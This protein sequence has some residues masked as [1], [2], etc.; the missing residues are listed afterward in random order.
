MSLNVLL[1]YPP[2]SEP[3]WKPIKAAIRNEGGN[4]HKA[5]DQ[6][7]LLAKGRTGKWDLVVSTL[8]LA[9]SP[10][11]QVVDSRGGL[12]ALATFQGRDLHLGLVLPFDNP[13]ISRQARFINPRP[14][15]FLDTMLQKELIDYLRDLAPRTHYL[16]IVIKVSPG[17][18]WKYEMWADG[19][20]F[21]F[22]PKPLNIHPGQ[23]E[24]WQ[25]LSEPI[26]SGT[27]KWRESFESLGK[28]LISSFSKGSKSFAADLQAGIDAAGG[29]ANTRLTFAISTEFYPI[30]LE[31]IFMHNPPEPWLTYAPLVRTLS[32]KR[33]PRVEF[34]EPGSGFV[35]TLVICANV[36][37][38]VDELKTAQGTAMAFKPLPNAEKE[39]RMLCSLLRRGAKRDLPVSEPVLVGT[40]QDPLTPSRL[41]KLLAE[42]WDIIHFAGHAHYE[43][44]GK[45]GQGYLIMPSDE[46]GRLAAVDI[47]KIGPQ[48]R[49]N[50]KLLY[51]SSC[52]SA[53]A[54]FAQEAA[55]RGVSAVIGFGSPVNDRCAYLCAQRFYLGLMARRTIEAAF[56]DARRSLHKRRMPNDNTWAS[57][58]L[59]M[60]RRS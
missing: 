38:Q 30:A 58:V 20:D 24:A 9:K 52:R 42:R 45:F 7:D 33:S 53:S 4:V 57:G 21:P 44:H 12:K 8:D 11:A 27:E 51:L 31:S 28:H 22:R 26:L 36:D 60:G 49:D 10:E 37:G 16:D 3:M 43:R 23:P 46:R 25:M 59:V 56:L 40:P 55:N 6:E 48:L 18:R 34:L 35:R 1:A 41:R 39:C 2:T 15:I 19:F 50:V 29:V 5:D 17:G 14:E 13:A 32:Q 54:A 47:T